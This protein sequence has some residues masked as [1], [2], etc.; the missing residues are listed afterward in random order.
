MGC[1]EE[2]SGEFIISGCEFAPVFEAAEE[3]LDAVALAVEI[4]VM[5][6]W[7]FGI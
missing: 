3:V 6:D 1:G 2:V 4:G 7:F 5:R